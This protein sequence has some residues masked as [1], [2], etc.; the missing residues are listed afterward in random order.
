MLSWNFERNGADDSERRL[1]AHELLVSLNPHLILRQEM[2]GAD[3]R[4]REIMYELEDVLGLRGWLGPRSSTGVFA[5]PALFQPLREWPDVGP[6]WVQPPTALTFRFVPAGF[7]AM[8][9]A[10]VSYHLNYASS[11]NRQAE[12]EW[13]T[14]WADK[15]W[16][17]PQGKVARVPA[18]LAGDNNS[19]PSPDDEDVPLPELR[20]IADE[21]HRV[22]RSVTDD[23]G[24]RVM[25]TRPDQVLRLAGLEDVAW[26]CTTARGGGD[27][28]LAR[29]V[30]AC[31]TH[32]PDSRI[33]RIYATTDLLHAVVGV[34]V[35]EVPEDVSDHHIVRLRLDAESLADILNRQSGMSPAA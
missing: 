31:E 15:R 10:V 25:D 26:H 13:L 14:T 9:M 16:T 19:Y 12:A 3:A 22:H 29:T 32:G 2:W 27:K 33:D 4:G 21:P 1:R 5:D 34:D 20:A 35:I 8:P 24:Q 17:T 11:T 28:A 6:M 18:L 7:D 30:N 23:T